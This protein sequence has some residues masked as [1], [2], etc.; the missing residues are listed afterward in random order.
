MIG[1]SCL[2]CPFWRVDDGV[3]L[4]RETCLHQDGTLPPG[5][6]LPIGGIRIGLDAVSSVSLHG[7]KD[8]T[9]IHVPSLLLSTGSRNRAIDK[10]QLFNTQPNDTQSFSQNFSLGDVTRSNAVFTTN[11]AQEPEVREE[12]FAPVT[13]DLAK[14]LL[15]NSNTHEVYLVKRDRVLGVVLRAPGP[16]RVR[17]L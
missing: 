8:S 6:Q 13:T 14:T 11:N 5:P 1:P 3:V 17:T 16:K 9:G 2:C 4:L 12:V 7:S 10:A 15:E